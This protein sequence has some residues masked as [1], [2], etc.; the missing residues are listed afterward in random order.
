MRWKI[1]IVK[2]LNDYLEIVVQGIL[3]TPTR[4]RTGRRLKNIGLLPREVVGL[5]LVCAVGREIAPSENW[6]LSSDPDQRDGIIVCQSG[7]RKGE[8]FATEQVYIPPHFSGNLTDLV[9]SEI[10]RKSSK[11]KEYGRDRHLI[12]FCDKHGLLDHQQIKKEVATNEVFYS[13]WLIGRA[14]REGWSYFVFSPKTVSDPVM[15]YK[16][17]IGK[18]FRGWE[19]KRLGRL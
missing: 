1:N 16:V 3:K 4:L 8:A 13:Y 9:L 5:F 19:V 6:T 10:A 14:S 15:A 17:V 2:N 18:D 11:G 12:I 7:S